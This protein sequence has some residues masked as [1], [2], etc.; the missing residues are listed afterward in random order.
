M[1]TNGLMKA[2]LRNPGF[3]YGNTSFW[4][5]AGVGTI[6]VD[7]AQ[8][9]EGTYSGKVTTTAGSKSA[10]VVHDDLIPVEY[11]EVAAYSVFMRGVAADEVSLRMKTY[12]SDGNHRNTG[13][14]KNC[15]MNGGWMQIQSQYIAKIDESYVQ[16]YLVFSSAL[17]SAEYHIDNL[18][19]HVVA[20]GAQAI[21]K[22]EIAD[23]TNL[24]A[25]GDTTSDLYK[26]YGFTN[27]YAEIECTSLTGTNPT[28]DVDIAE[29]DVYGNERILGSFSLFSTADDQRIGISKPIGE[30][31]YV[32]YTEGGS[33]TDCDLAVTII[34]VR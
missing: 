27:Y 16:F 2:K 26:M 32:K 23:L 3:E 28:L 12:D 5:I 22:L 8:K 4:S 20:L 33:W 31:M 11:G 7:T 29:L 1:D 14:V 15:V 25:T 19:I 18:D 30:G 13:I 17:G 9:V 34:G 10:D 21:Q 24:T 6:E